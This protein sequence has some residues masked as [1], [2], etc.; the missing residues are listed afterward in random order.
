MTSSTRG[1]ASHLRMP[2]SSASFSGKDVSESCKAENTLN[3]FSRFFWEVSAVSDLQ[4]SPQMKI[5]NKVEVN[6]P[7]K[8]WCRKL[9]YWGVY[10]HRGGWTEQGAGPFFISVVLGM[11]GVC[12]AWERCRPAGL[13]V[14]VLPLFQ[15]QR[16]LLPKWQEVPKSKSTNAQKSDLASGLAEVLE[17]SDEA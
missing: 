10:M 17:R 12:E 3:I 5:Q 11:L 8:Q 6:G 15:R 2:V 13:K 9:C 16:Q 4:I 1:S 14:T 7:C